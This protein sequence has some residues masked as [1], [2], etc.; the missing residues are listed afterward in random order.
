MTAFPTTFIWGAASA[1]YQIE[2]AVAEDGRGESIW[3]VF[4]RQPNAVW[5]RQTGDIACDH[6]HRFAEDVALMKEI[7]LKGYRFSVAWPRVFPEGTGAVN[8]KGLEFY[9]RLVDHLLAAGIAPF[10]TLYHWDLPQA[11]F[12]RGGWNN[13]ESPEWFAAYVATVVEKLSDRVAHWMTFNEPQIFLGFGLHYGMHAPVGQRPFNE[14]LAAG[15]NVLLAHGRAVQAIRAHAKTPASVGLAPAAMIAM[16]A[17]DAPA[18]L[19][20]ARHVTF[21]VK[22]REL[23]LPVTP[24][25]CLNNA[26]WMD[27][28]FLGEYPADALEYFGADAPPIASGDMDLI[29]QPLD[30]CGMNMYFGAAVH[31]DEKGEVALIPAPP[32]HPTTAY[33]WPVTPDV[34]YWGPRFFHERYGQPIYVTENG[35]SCRDWISLDDTVH[36]PQRID[37]LTRYLRQLGRA[38]EDGVPVH[39]YFHWSATDNFEW[40]H[41]YKERFG[42]IYVDYPT[43]RRVLKDSAHWYRQVIATNGAHLTHNVP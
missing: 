22:Y 6:Y 24:K 13:A 25:N 19:E 18:D 40:S 32:G 12:A 1:A 28:I 4:C 23:F 14:V 36:D 41:G 21:S 37:F 15:H 26:W 43:Q 3:D 9:D 8:A 38:L 2:G 35:V 10:L 5:N 11:L 31:A 17:T 27:P 20:L 33:D 7:G 16:P 30:F 42:L 34:L 39:G 29:R